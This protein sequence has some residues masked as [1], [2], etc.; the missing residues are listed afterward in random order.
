MRKLK[1]CT[2]QKPGVMRTHTNIYV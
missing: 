2:S 1:I